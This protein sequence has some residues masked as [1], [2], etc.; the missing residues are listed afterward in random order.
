ML[1]GDM[2]FSLPLHLPCTPG[3]V[4]LRLNPVILESS[5]SQEMPSLFLCPLHT[6]F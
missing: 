1:E 2:A 3:H 5:Y 4:E 6:P